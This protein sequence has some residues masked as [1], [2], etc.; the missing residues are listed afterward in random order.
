MSAVRTIAVAALAGALSAC[1]VRIGQFATAGT[2][3][4]APPATVAPAERV[5]GSSCR[6]WVL[7]LT[8]GLPRMEDA[9][10]DA[11][12]R[13]GTVWLRDVDLDSVHPFYGPVGR[14]CYVVT[15]TPWRPAAP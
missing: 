12:A 6:W 3:A 7:G 14:H 11:V 8:L 10:A 5:T 1:T 4:D 15:G 9:L 13:A 2:A